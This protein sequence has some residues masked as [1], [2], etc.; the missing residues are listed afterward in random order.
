MADGGQDRGTDAVD[1]RQLGRL[2]R[3][4]GR[5]ERTGRGRRELPEQSAVL[6]EQ[7]GSGGDQTKAVAGRGGQL[8]VGRVDRRANRGH[9]VLRPAVGRLQQGNARHRERVADVA[10]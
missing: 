5:L 2:I 1:L 8:R 7:L 10:Q 4:P 6:G 3:L 9:D